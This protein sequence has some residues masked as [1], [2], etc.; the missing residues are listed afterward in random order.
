MSAP[1]DYSVL[2]AAE[3]QKTI[4]AVCKRTSD[5]FPDA[6]LAN[7][8]LRLLAISNQAA[9]RSRL[10]NRPI[11][12]VRILSMVIVSVVVGLCLDIP[13]LFSPHRGSLD[14][15]EA[16]E[17]LE[18]AMNIVVLIG[19]LIYFFISLER[20]FKRGKALE[21]IHELRSVAHIID[22][23]QLS[24][25][26]EE[27][28]ELSKSETEAGV[29]QLTRTELQKYLDYCSEFLSL[30]GKIAALYVQGFDDPVTIA[31]VNEV[32][33]L[34]TGLSRKIWQKIMILHEAVGE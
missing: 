18:P 9:E 25:D 7:V 23:H 27:L 10:I 14:W 28:L 13:W 17:L 12:W 24:K 16:V 11:Y 26:P 19:A 2:S 4:S 33:E 5:R 34:C 30:T 15:V 22:M 29:R 1:G 21:A 32:E 31:S 20:R 3:I 8:G 6:G